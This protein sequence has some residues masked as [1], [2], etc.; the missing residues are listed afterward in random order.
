MHLLH[1]YTA[2]TTATYTQLQGT[3]TAKVCVCLAL[4]SI[5]LTIQGR[6]R[7]T[8]H[9][10]WWCRV[11]HSSFSSLHRRR[12]SIALCTADTD[13]HTLT[14]KKARAIRS[15]RNTLTSKAVSPSQRRTGDCWKHQPAPKEEREREL[16][17]VTGRSCCC[18]CDGAKGGRALGERDEHTLMLVVVEEGGRR[19][20]KSCLGRRALLS[21]QQ[22][23]QQNHCL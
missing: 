20:K 3:M 22:Q 12:S 18:C 23:Q 19:R 15:T 6:A 1:V 13:A 21:Q 7:H 11:Q 10:A 9:K 5:K 2:E 14:A 16:P 8:T 4:C 17:K